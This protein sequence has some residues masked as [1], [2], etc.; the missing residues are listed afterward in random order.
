MPTKGRR[1]ILKRYKRPTSVDDVIG[2]A[3]HGN[4]SYLDLS[5]WG[6]TELNKSVMSLTGVLQDLDLSRNR[7]SVLP[8]FIGKFKNL[9]TLRLSG[10]HLVELPPEIG[11]LCELKDLRV[12]RNKIR[13][14]PKAIGHLSQ[15]R[16]LDLSEN[17]LTHLPQTLGNLS[18][19]EVLDLS[20]NKLTTLPEWIGRLSSLRRLVLESNRIAQLPH[21]IRNLQCLTELYLNGNPGLDLPAEV[22]GPTL[23]EILIDR[24]HR[25]DAMKIIEYYFRVRGGRHPL[26]EAKLILVGRGAVGKTSLVNRLVHNRFDKDEKKTEGINITQWRVGLRNGEDVRLNVWDFGGQ[27]IMHATHQFFLTQRSL[28]LLVL[29]G[30]EGGE[31]KDA[32]YWLKLIES[33]GN[34]SPVIIVLNKITEQAFDLNRRALRLKYA[35]IVRNGFISTDCEDATGIDELRQ[36][37]ERETDGLEHLRDAFPLSWFAIK[38]TLATMERNYLTFAEY[39]KT[40]AENGEPDRIAQETLSTYLHNLGIILNYKDDP[41]LHDTHVLNPHWVTR[42]IYKILNSRRLAKSRGHIQLR[43][44]QT[45]F[46]EKEYPQSMHRFIVDLMKK[47]E[48]CFSYQDDDCSYLVP[49]LLD[50]QEP[51]ETASFRPADCLNFEYHYPILPEG[52][53]PR[54]IVRTHVLSE[55]LPRWRSGVILKFGESHALV[56]ADAEDKRVFIH[57]SGKYPRQRIELLGIIR[58]DFER[59]HHDIRNLQPQAMVPTPGNSG[60]LIPYEE[61]LV[62][63]RSGLDKVPKVVGGKLIELDVQ[64]L[65]NGVELETRQQRQRANK[66]DGAALLFYSYS[67]KD[68]GLRNELGNHLK[69]LR[70]QGVIAPWHDRKI[71]AGDEWKGRI[72]QN[73][74]R[75][76]I[77]LMLVSSDFLASDYCYEIEMKRAL[78]RHKSGEACVI[79]VIVR[80]VNWSSAPFANIQALP[81]DGKAVTLWS[82]RDVAWRHVCEEI[83]KVARRFVTSARQE[84]E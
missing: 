6:I 18:R 52:L 4:R 1:R 14:L 75:A 56:K 54:F 79:P 43:D 61:L 44:L 25:V 41:R 60:V 68:E 2:R 21:S 39:R 13:T 45:L 8:G 17:D 3:Q 20:H 51:E 74:E 42:G 22:V 70:R 59:I 19:L 11:A 23:T 24:G 37:I 7:L 58:S 30:R 72:D 63:E 80:D 38:D 82:D 67:H 53:L 77:I 50:K 15:L 55:G 29:S 40:C 65:L 73:L 28:Y 34:E 10:N 64:E 35:F 84:D 66:G 33:F 81:K 46:D 78:E 12:A 26:N 49:E 9:T 57:V 36:V 27:E 83:E 47:F 16:E 5:E 76:D 62:M 71:E 31:D 48:L 69:I 32:E